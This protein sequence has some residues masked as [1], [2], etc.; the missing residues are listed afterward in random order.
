MFEAIGAT[1]QVE[2][3]KRNIQNVKTALEARKGS[4]GDT[5]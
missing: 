2:Q 4:E 1:P 5:V 3:T